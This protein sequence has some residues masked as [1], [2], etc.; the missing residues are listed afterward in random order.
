MAKVVPVSGT[1]HSLGHCRSGQSS[2]GIWR[3]K[4]VAEYREHAQECRRLAQSI[5]SADHKAALIS[6]AETWESLAQEREARLTREA[7]KQN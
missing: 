6:M 2:P 1:Q 4:T 3:L 7:N 5:R